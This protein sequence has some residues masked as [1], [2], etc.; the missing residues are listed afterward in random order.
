MK[1]EIKQYPKPQ[2]FDLHEAA[3]TWRLPYWDWAMK[4]PLPENPKKKDYNVPLVVLTEKVEIRLPTVDGYGPYPNA[5]Y[6]FTMPGGIDMGHESLE[7]TDPL[8]DLRITPSLEKYKPKG[9]K[10]SETVTIHVCLQCLYC[11]NLLT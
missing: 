5:F 1:E 4:K 3:R 9:Q 10:E 8:K 2:R 7:N 6:Q 11:H